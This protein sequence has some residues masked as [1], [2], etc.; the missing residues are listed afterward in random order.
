MP[1]YTVH[2]PPNAGA[3]RADPER[4]VFVRDG[5]YFWAFAAG[6]ALAA[7]CTGCGWR[8]WSIYRAIDRRIGGILYADRR[9]VVCNSLIGLPV[10]LLVGFEA[11]TIRRWT[12]SRRGWRTL[13]FVV[14]ED[15][16]M[17]EQRFYAEWAK[18]AR[19]SAAAGRAGA[20]NIQRRCGAGRRRR[21]T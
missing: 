16:E 2:A 15:E 6:A 21:A 3:A 11:A 1:T 9:A 12:L 19:R 5:F 14:A 7:A 4:F 18:R 13:G 8:C 10:A 17:A 20:R